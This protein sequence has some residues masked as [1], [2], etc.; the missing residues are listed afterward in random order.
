MVKNKKQISLAEKTEQILLTMPRIIATQIGKD[1]LLQKQQETKLNFEIKK[2][3]IQNKKLSDKITFLK[4]KNTTASKK[5]AIQ[6]QKAL[7]KTQQGLLS[8]IREGEA[9]KKQTQTLSKKKAMYA[10]LQAQILN[11]KKDWDKKGSSKASK[12]RV[13][14]KVTEMKKM[15]V[16]LVTEPQEGQL[17]EIIE[18]PEPV[19]VEYVQEES[20]ENVS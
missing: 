9:L 7:Q 11:F 5:Q 19:E 10:A 4:K 1:L 13:K 20:M 16:T 18:T 12:R 15:P 17:L 14:P 3:Q 6:T 2:L 8:L